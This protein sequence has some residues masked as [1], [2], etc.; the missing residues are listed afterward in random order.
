V[1]GDVRLREAAGVDEVTHPLLTVAQRLEDAQPR[2]VCETVKE[3][4]M[5]R[6][7]DRRL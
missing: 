6:E 7:C 5:N 3:T 1:L 4:A 2:R